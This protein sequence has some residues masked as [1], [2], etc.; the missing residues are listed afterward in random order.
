MARRARRDAR[1]AER[2]ADGAGS[3]DGGNPS[4]T[5]ASGDSGSVIDPGTIGRS[6]DSGN[7][8]SGDGGTGERPRRGRKPGSR[9][10]QKT[11]ESDLDTIAATLLVGCSLIADAVKAPELIPE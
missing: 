7:G 10:K 11:P 2:P 6:A 1:D 5:A 9:N 8:D 3:G 4:E